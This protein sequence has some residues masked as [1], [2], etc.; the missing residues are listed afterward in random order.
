MR[1]RE[2]IITRTL[3]LFAVLAVL[4]VSPPADAAQPANDKWQFSI[5]PYLW[6]PTIDGTLQFHGRAGGNPEVNVKANPGDYLSDLEMAL[7]LAFEVRKGKW[8]LHSDVTCKDQGSEGGV[9]PEVGRPD[10][11]HVRR[12]RSDRGE[13]GRCEDVGPK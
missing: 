4:L 8:L 1:P 2:A 10:R 3:T 7:L 11:P 5:T 6:L 13:G 9:E 12:W